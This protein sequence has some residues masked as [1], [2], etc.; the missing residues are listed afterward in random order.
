MLSAF[1]LLLVRG[2]ASITIIFMPLSVILSS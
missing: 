1:E 2:A